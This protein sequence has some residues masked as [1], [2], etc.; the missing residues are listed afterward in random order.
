M[1]D[2]SPFFALAPWESIS[3]LPSLDSVAVQ[4]SGYD[5]SEQDGKLWLRKTHDSREGAFLAMSLMHSPFS[6]Y[7]HAPLAWRNYQPSAWRA[8]LHNI[9]SK[10]KVARIFF[11]GATGK[12]RCPQEKATYSVTVSATGWAQWTIYEDEK[13]R[14]TAAFIWTQDPELAL[15]LD[16]P[17]LDVWTQIQ[18]QWADENSD[19]AF[20]WR[21]LELS[22]SQ[23]GDLIWR[24]G[25]HEI[26]HAHEVVTCW[27][28]MQTRYWENT[29]FVLISVDIS[30]LDYHEEYR[31]SM[32]RILP[33]GDSE[34]LPVSDI[35]NV[36][37]LL[38]SRFGPLIYKA[39]LEQHLC[40]RH[41]TEENPLLLSIQVFAPT[42]HEV[43]EASFQWRE[44]L[45][46][47]SS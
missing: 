38:L 8:S 14:Q 11:L 45:Q 39:R 1:P 9:L 40:L 36:F 30:E 41:W 10:G 23:I 24:W 13:P 15:F 3:D 19:C 21:T 6:K 2:N 43:L 20:A 37:Q 25:N 46:S 4:H 16:T 5:M 18:T 27:L 32:R 33:T 34:I 31:L 28:H 17:S 42:A 44:W 12:L 26:S 22:V 47:S 35:D 7:G 29:E